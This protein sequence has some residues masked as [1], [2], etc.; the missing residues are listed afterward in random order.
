VLSDDAP[1]CLY[2]AT[3]P[4]PGRWPALSGV[5]DADVLV[6][7]AGYTGLSAALHLAQ[8]GRR[9]V[10]LEAEE[11]GWGA[12]GRNGGQVN[13][14][15]KHEPDDVEAAL[16]PR[17]GPRLVALAGDAPAALFRLIQ[18]LAIDCEVQRGGTLRLATA[19]RQV[20][21]L[22]RSRAQWARRGV[23]LAWLGPDAVAAAT[24][25]GRYAGGL[26]DPRG[27]AVQ[28]LKLVRGLARA[29]A[30]AGARLHD[31]SRV[32]ALRRERDRWRGESAGGA[33]RAEQVV[34]ATDGYSDGL[35]PG[36]ARSIVPIYSAIAATEP[37]TGDAAAAILPG[38]PAAYEV[39]D[40]TI[41][42]RIDASGRL[43]MGGRGRQRATSRPGDYAHLVRYAR[44]LWPALR[45]V[46]FPYCWNGQFALAPDFYPRLHAPARGIWA[47]LGYSGRGVALA[48]AVGAELA[49]ACT[50][51]PAEE[52]ALPLTPIR[53]I[54]L[55][56]LWRAG[57]ALRVLAGRLRDR[58]GF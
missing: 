39:G 22:E 54:P 48:V 38:R 27:G 16:G 33:V 50:G 35:W 5:V 4:D 21:A 2:A 51:T 28:P 8:S 58:V 55:H 56:G 17:F 14:G 10:V 9:V 6:V 37:L 23:E 49:R 45:D 34:L 12:A 20:P 42:Y 7:G 43:L 3:A 31:G 19:D 25:T 26:L 32:R 36:L 24:G 15:L 40:V 11:P 53:P 44:R 47:G 18:A 30:A 13:P 46:D 52:L 29:A 1:G 57:V 41:Y